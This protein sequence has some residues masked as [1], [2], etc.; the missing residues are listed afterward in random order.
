MVSVEMKL[1]KI[2]YA[3][4]ISTDDDD[5]QKRNLNHAVFWICFDRHVIDRVTCF[6]SDFGLVICSDHVIYCVHVICF[7]HEIHY[8]H[9][10]C[11]DYAHA[12][13]FY[14]VTHFFLLIYFAHARA[15]LIFLLI[16]SG[17]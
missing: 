7:V 11:L 17:N 8:V 5:N 13:H 3:L 2:A 9:D 1:K 12:I 14:R 16:Y 10:F 6:E 4:L 15:I